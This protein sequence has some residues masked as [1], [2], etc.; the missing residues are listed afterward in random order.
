MTQAQ[1]RATLS[2]LVNETLTDAIA[3]VYLTISSNKII[4]RLYPFDNSQ[5][6]VPPQYEMLQCELACRLY[7]KRGAEGETIHNENGIN[8][9]YG[10]DEDL[11]STITPFARV[12]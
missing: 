7:L 1:K 10:G 6:E 11:L 3:D 5:Y 4:D 8:R 12:V 2:T 9:T